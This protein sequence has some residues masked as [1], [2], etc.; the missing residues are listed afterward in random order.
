MDHHVEE[1]ADGQPDQ[2]GQRGQ[3]GHVT[4]FTKAM[5]VRF[6]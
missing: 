6:E 1:R 5:F 3:Q 2:A 4:S